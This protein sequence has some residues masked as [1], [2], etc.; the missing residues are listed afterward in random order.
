MVH[1]DLIRVALCGSVDDGKSTFT[2]RLLYD[3]DLLY[4][5]TLKLVDRDD[6][7]N[8]N[9]ANITDGL[10]KEVTEGI[11]VDVAH[12]YFQKDNNKYILADCPGHKEY[13]QNMFTGVSN[14]DVAILLTD[15]KNGLTDQT[16]RHIEI[17]LL[18]HV[19]EIIVAVNK[20]D[21]VDWS[22][23]RFRE[24]RENVLELFAGRHSNICFVPI[25]ALKGDNVVDKI[26]K[27]LVFVEANDERGFTQTML[28]SWYD[29]PTIME[30]L[31]MYKAPERNK[32]ASKIIK[33]KQ[34]GY[35]QH[36]CGPA[37]NPSTQRVVLDSRE[38]LDDEVTLD[39]IELPISDTFKIYDRCGDLY[40]AS[41]NAACVS[42]TIYTHDKSLIR[43]G[44]VDA[45]TDL[46]WFASAIDPDKEYILKTHYSDYSVVFKDTSDDHEFNVTPCKV[47]CTDGRI[48]EG[49]LSSIYGLCYGDREQYIIIDPE[50]NSVVGAGVLTF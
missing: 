41:V 50:T 44:M 49:S 20:M 28:G 33:I 38:H 4:E 39:C 3:A 46:F 13:I 37:S 5:D 40:W 10:K 11:T 21:L 34:T 7:G 6:D 48:L 17:L 8:I 12:R 15:A 2:G 45:D 30:L 27:P 16:R 42:G 22:E 35:P 31:R 24:I 32:H 47:H 26:V 29:G 25:S 19:D 18:S 36:H 23:E 43:H 9:L 14:S 1:G